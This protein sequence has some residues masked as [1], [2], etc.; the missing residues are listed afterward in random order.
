MA[1]DWLA[2]FKARGGRGVCVWTPEERREL[3]G[4][5]DYSREAA[6]DARQEELV[7][8]LETG[9][10][11]TKADAKEARRIQRAHFPHPIR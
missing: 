5:C 7:S 4:D 6:R 3:F 8:R 11:L 10:P 2:E 9:L 1:R